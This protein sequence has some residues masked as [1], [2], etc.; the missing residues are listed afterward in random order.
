MNVISVPT[1]VFY[2]RKIQNLAVFGCLSNHHGE[3]PVPVGGFLAKRYRNTLFYK[4]RLQLYAK[5]WI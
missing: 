3:F 5:K 4:L 1:K 2:A